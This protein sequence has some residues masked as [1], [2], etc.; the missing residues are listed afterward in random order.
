M[1]KRGEKGAGKKL[2]EETRK[3]I[4]K[5]VTQ[6]FKDT[7]FT[8]REAE[9]AWGIDI[10]TLSK[11][12]NGE[13]AMGAGFL[14]KLRDVV[15]M[16]I[17]EILGL[18][19]IG[20]KAPIA[21]RW[22]ATIEAAVEETKAMGAPDVVIRH[23][24]RTRAMIAEDD[25]ERRLAWVRAILKTWSL[26]S[27]APPVTEPARKWLVTHPEPE[28]AKGDAVEDRDDLKLATG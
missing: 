10:S 8:V 17:D 16:P 3:R 1:P 23:V 9:K 24:L 2:P 21:E 28:P 7:K 5:L 20:T 18:S 12:R 4:A 26:W 6:L 13:G 11:A 14:I 22:K 27:L 19:P 25:D 15:K